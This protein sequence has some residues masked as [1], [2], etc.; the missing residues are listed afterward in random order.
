MNGPTYDPTLVAVLAADERTRAI[1]IRARNDCAGM[2]LTT[3]AVWNALQDL[4]GA[5]CRFHKSMPSDDR[6]E[7]LFDVYDVFVEQLPVYLKFKITSEAAGDNR[8]VVV[9]SFKRNEQYA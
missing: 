8:I 9:V 6:P 2:G 5:G 1:T 3:D 4:H 7:D